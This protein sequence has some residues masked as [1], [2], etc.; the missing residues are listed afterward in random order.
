MVRLPRRAAAAAIAVLALTG[1]KPMA[2]HDEVARLSSPGDSNLDA[3]L[4]EVNTGA[5]DTFKYDVFVLPKGSAVPK[6]PA[7]SLIGATRN[8]QA[9]GANLRWQG[10]THLRVEYFEARA[11]QGAAGVIQV[12]GQ[13]VWIELVQGIRDPEAPP[14]GMDYNQQKTAGQAGAAR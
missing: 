10:P 1:C 4:V 3:V 14:G 6:K 11:V 8:E 5:T 13:D 12:G 7:L 9:Y 2:S